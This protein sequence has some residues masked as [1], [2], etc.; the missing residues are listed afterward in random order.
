MLARSFHRARAPKR[1]SFHHPSLSA[2]AG[3][4]GRRRSSAVSLHRLHDISRESLRDRLATARRRA[5]ARGCRDST[6]STRFATT[7]VVI[8]VVMSRLPSRIGRIGVRA[9]R[10]RRRGR[11]QVRHQRL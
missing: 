4:R 6:G 2:S 10:A 3:Q 9:L 1:L 5:R 11:L 8:V 7:L